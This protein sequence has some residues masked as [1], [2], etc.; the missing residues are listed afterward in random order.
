MAN[1]NLSEERALVSRAIAREGIILLENKNNTLP[2]EQEPV[3]VFGRT[4][5]DMIQGGT[6]SALCTSEYCVNILTGL[7]NAG[8][9]VD[10]ELAGVYRKWCND[11]LWF[12]SVFGE[13]ALM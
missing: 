5:I 7:E 3:A 1:Y 10:Q 8:V 12:P 11:N 6:G 4:Q 13:A 9:Q 2:L